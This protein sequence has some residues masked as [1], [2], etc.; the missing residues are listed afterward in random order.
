MKTREDIFIIWGR[1]VK[2]SQ[3]LA[4]ALDARPVQVYY[5]RWLG[6]RIPWAMRYAF[7]TL[8]TW[9]E[10][11]KSRPK[12]VYVQNPPV[13][14]PLACLAYC[15]L[16]RAKLVI[17]S[18]TA[19]FLEDKWTRFNRLFRFVAK[20]AGLNTCHNYKN[21]EIL[22]G[23][24]LTP[25]MTLQFFNPCFDETE[26]RKPLS[27]PRLES[28]VKL[29]TPMVLMVNRFAS[30][31]DYLTVIE[32]ARIAPEINFFIVGNSDD[33]TDMPKDLP[34]NIYL[35]G[36]VAHAE[37]MKL[38]YCSQVVLAFTR[39]VDTV[40]WS[41]R[42]IL[43]L[44]KPFVTVDSEVMRYYFSEVALFAKSDADEIRKQTIAAM[45]NRETM[46]ANSEKF[47][48][49]DRE[50]WNSDIQRVKEILHS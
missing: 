46:S 50:R 10:L 32:T 6:L 41:I 20:R 22:R 17:D 47:L 18:H 26:L 23:W 7:Q 29:E 19:A 44:R 3:Y 37:F 42:E 1:E 5:D 40:L 33:V 25:I 45:N 16:F 43:A 28:V 12:V 39:R 38:M 35:T 14:A 30:D 13:I 31:D 11:C 9:Y 24:N 15:K 49:K 4:E 27:N 2:L 34:S 21:L 8:G 48:I 36:Y